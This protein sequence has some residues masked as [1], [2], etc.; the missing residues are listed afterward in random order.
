[1]RPVRRANNS[2]VLAVSNV[3]VRMDAQHSIPSLSLTCYGKLYL[4][5]S[6]REAAVVATGCGGIAPLD[7][8]L[9]TS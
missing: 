2:T 9:G 4:F 3:K 5:S 1:M 6:S 8:N 7:L